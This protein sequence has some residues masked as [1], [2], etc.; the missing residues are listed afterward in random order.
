MGY[1]HANRD[2]EREITIQCAIEAISRLPFQSIRAIAAYFQ[3]PATT[4]HYRLYSRQLRTKGH[5]HFQLLSD[6]EE[7]ALAKW[8]T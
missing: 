4:L 5:E 7:S 8:V 2:P 3:V 6:I 1:N